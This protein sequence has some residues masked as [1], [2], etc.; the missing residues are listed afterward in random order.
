MRRFLRHH[1]LLL[2]LLILVFG[3]NAGLGYGACCDEM[4]PSDVNGVVAEVMA[5]AELPPCHKP[6]SSSAVEGET[7]YD[8]ETC[9]ASCVSALPALVVAANKVPIGAA[10]YVAPFSFY[11]F[12]N[13]D[14]P[15]RPPSLPLA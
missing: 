6:A 14:T 7:Q 5:E 2:Q 12:S 1:R 15:Y 3:M 9:C 11:V 4:L 8:F 10:E 13:I